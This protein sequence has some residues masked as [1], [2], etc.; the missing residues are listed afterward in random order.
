MN[1]LLVRGPA[2]CLSSLKFTQD[3]HNHLYPSKFFRSTAYPKCNCIKN[4]VPQGFSVLKS[5][6][7]C[8][9]GS[10]WSSMAFYLFSVHVPLSFGGLSAV[11]SILHCSALDPQTEALSLV[12]L[13]MLELI[14][15]LL[16]LRCTGNPQYKLRD[17]FQE[18]QSTRE[19][20]W[21]LASALGFV[22]LVVL[23]F[24]TSI[25]ADT[26]VGT[27]EVNNPILKEILSSGPISITSCILV[28]CIITPLL[29]EIVY[30]GFFLTALSSTMK[31][32]EAVIV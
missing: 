16:L 1:G 28:Y 20:N 21:L 8:D 31:W 14:V 15:V 6:T 27:K 30:R 32:Q 19:R 23:V 29:E 7:P 11:T 13:Q 10:L 18:K 24:V 5:D 2:I 9:R 26:L 3:F 22:F 17:F 12:V 25:I 4:K